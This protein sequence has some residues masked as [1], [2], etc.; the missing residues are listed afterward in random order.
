MCCMQH[1]PTGARFG[2]AAIA[3]APIARGRSALGAPASATPRSRSKATTNT[4]PA[5]LP[6]PHGPAPG[7]ERGG[8]RPP[9][10][11]PPSRRARA[12]PP[13]PVAARLRCR[14]QR[15]IAHPSHP[16]LHPCSKT[17]TQR[18]EGCFCAPRRRPTR[19]SACWRCAGGWSGRAAAGPAV[20]AFASRGVVELTPSLS[21]PLPDGAAAHA[22]PPETN[23]R[24]ALLY[25]TTDL[26]RPGRGFGDTPTAVL[27]HHYLSK[28]QL[29]A[30]CVACVWCLHYHSVRARGHGGSAGALLP[31][32][33]ECQLR[34]PRCRGGGGSRAAPSALHVPSCVAWA[35]AIVRP[36]H[37][38]QM[39]CCR[40]AAFCTR[41]GEAP[42]GRN[43]SLPAGQLLS[44]Q[45]SFF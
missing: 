19:W 31:P 16:P 22:S 32:P 6:L 40:P 13:P 39:R 4:W 25:A 44:R 28:R 3:L 20:G 34:A 17:G 23:S 12:A 1:G 43:A 2:L 11:T 21:R 45:P 27:G 24:R 41:S 37:T 10:P 5:A 8:P 36:G 33:L 42:G 14:R 7:P 18:W 38:A 29:G 9:R 30:L 35:T 26:L 15:R